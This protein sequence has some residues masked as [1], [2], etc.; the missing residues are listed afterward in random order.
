MT[1]RGDRGSPLL[2]SS[3]K[4]HSKD[5]TSDLILV[6]N[7]LKMNLH[8]NSFNK[9]PTTYEH[10]IYNYLLT[11]KDQQQH[12][13]HTVSSQ[14]TLDNFFSAS[15]ILGGC[16][17]MAS[18]SIV[19]LDT[20]HKKQSQLEKSPLRESSET[21]ASHL[22]RDQDVL[23]SR[24]KER[25]LRGDRVQ[26]RESIDEIMQQI[27]I[28]PQPVPQPQK[29]VFSYQSQVAHERWREKVEMFRQTVAAKKIQRLLKAYVYYKRIQRKAHEQSAERRRKMQLIKILAAK[30]IVKHVKAWLKRRK[31]K[32]Q[33]IPFH[34][35]V[36]IQKWWRRVIKKKRIAQF[37]RFKQIMLAA[38]LGWRTRRVVNSLA[39]EVQDY[40]NCEDGP[41]KQALKVM[42][43]NLYESVMQHKLWLLKNAR[44]IANLK[45]YQRRI[46]IQQ[47]QMMVIKE[48][49]KIVTSVK[50]VKTKSCSSSNLMNT[51]LITAKNIK[52]IEISPTMS[53][54][55]NR[56]DEKR[57]MQTHSKNSSSLIAKSK[58]DSSYSTTKHQKGT[59]DTFSQD[60]VKG[61]YDLQE[62]QRKASQQSRPQTCK[63]SQVST[64]IPNTMN[65]TPRINRSQN[66]TSITNVKIR[67]STDSAIAQLVVNRDH[68]GSRQTMGSTLS[69]SKCGGLSPWEKKP[70]SASSNNQIVRKRSN[71]RGSMKRTPVIMQSLNIQEKTLLTSGVNAKK[72]I[73][74]NNY[75]KTLTEIEKLMDEVQTH[76][77]F[78]Q[79]QI[80]SKNQK[81]LSRPTVACEFDKLITKLRLQMN[82][83]LNTIDPKFTFQ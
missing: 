30:V 21:T 69:G 19:F 82:G 26:T 71:E 16:A 25:R 80:T 23:S 83:M 33:T 17:S 47:N 36:F 5:S 11:N 9:E 81:L 34:Q 32:K 37:K 65:G 27:Q 45:Q 22:L 76:Q 55:N 72:S 13:I 20:T 59:F 8:S 68:S 38:F 74:A 54:Q 70:A 60:I 35:V 6:V 53:R 43:H 56:V 4:R 67:K 52:N 58:I 77:T 49:K 78:L 10:F 31:A 44:L 1:H 79:N 57:N 15:P 39:Q 73:A 50:H 3:S 41:S 48:D 24:S 66:R 18:D 51:K 63:E 29:G 75:K 64:N 46:T 28:K 62:Q 42:F 2:A 14:I 61:S 40:V 12:T 7:K